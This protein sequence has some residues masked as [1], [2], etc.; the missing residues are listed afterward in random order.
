MADCKLLRPSATLLFVGVLLTFLA[1]ILHPMEKDANNHVATFAQYA[2]SV[3]WTAIH[4][5]QFAGMAVIIAGLLVL[6]FALD[7]HSGSPALDPYRGK[8]PQ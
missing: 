2:S 3:N 1:G 6:F 5:V 8:K 7:V 4:L